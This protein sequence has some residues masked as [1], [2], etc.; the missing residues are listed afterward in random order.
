M[1]GAAGTAGRGSWRRRLSLTRDRLGA[2]LPPLVLMATVMLIWDWIVR[3][4]VISEFL[5]PRPLDVFGSAVG[6]M[7]EVVTG[8]PAAVHFL[9][10]LNEIVVGFGI[11]VVI[12][13]VIGVLMSEYERFARAVKPYVIAFNSTP[14]VAFAPLFIAWFGFGQLPKI[15]LIITIS[16]FPVIINAM[17]GLGATHPMEVR[18]MRSLGASRWQ[19]FKKLRFPNAMPYLFAGFELAIMT[20]SIGAVVG[21]F[22]GGNSGLG[23]ITILAQEAFNV[24]RTFATVVVLALQGVA[25]HRVVLLVRNRLV[26]WRYGA[27][28]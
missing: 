15:I 2:T 26:F 25:L 28:A 22:S 6:L 4:G 17:V 14:K 3:S 16:T 27:N 21:E 8:G 13:L 20:A 5:V 9:T 12:G 1:T 19:I 18:L 10:T 24:E 23:Y 7:Q 11:A